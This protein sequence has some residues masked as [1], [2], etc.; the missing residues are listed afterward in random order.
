MRKQFKHIALSMLM[1]STLS[2]V[3]QKN[4]TTLDHNALKS[5]TEKSYKAQILK[6]SSDEFL[7][8]KPFTKGDTL[9]TQY[10]AAEYKKLGLKPGNGKS[11]FQEV[12]MVEI[13]STPNVLLTLKSD[14]NQMTLH[15][16]SDYVVTSRRLQE[17]VELKNTALVFAGFG[18]VA[19]EYDWNDY[20]D[21]DVKG[22]TVV[23]MVND[24]GHYDKTLFKGDTM[25][26]YGRWTYKYE[27]AARQGAAGVLII[28]QTQ[29]ASYGWNVIR[30]GWGNAPQMDLDNVSEPNKYA[31]VEGWLSTE[32]ASKLFKLAGYDDSLLD[33]AKQKGFKAIPLGIKTDF[34]VSNKIK[35]SKSNNVIAI[36][37]GKSRKDEYIIYT[38]HWDHL[39]IGEAV[40][41]DSIYNGAIDNAAGVAALFEIAKAF[42]AA[43]KAPERSI[44]FLAVTSEEDGLL[45]SDYYVR[46]P[47]YALNKTVANINMDAFSAA[48]ATKDISIVGK[49]QSDMDDYAERSA[50]KFD[51]YT[52]AEGNPSSGGFYRSDHFN[53][54]KVGVPALYAGSGSDYIEQDTS[55][56]AGRKKALAGRYH[57]V[58]DEVIPEWNFDGMLAD[59]RLFFDIGYTL[60]QEATFPKWKDKSEFKEIGEKR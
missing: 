3:A 2:V 24:P 57:A 14:A 7:G 6:L 9:A 25:T 16:L 49:G 33:K 32:S 55:L 19:P 51:R 23:V 37:E 11:Y 59:I 56:I 15:N 44:V 39:G 58:N 8:R 13:T 1:A 60:S 48:G 35:K 34:E 31:Q 12:P 21:L 30:T 40:N 17:H 45:G 28:H 29:A 46:N 52:K 50:L 20:K 5:V 18:I 38:A 36:L 27:E 47:I 43:K 42:K 10:I 26:Y 4:Q 22:K 53:F 54:A 41:G